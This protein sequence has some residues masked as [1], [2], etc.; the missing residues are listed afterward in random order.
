MK[1]K[2]H[3]ASS[4]LRKKT[5]TR[6]DH[7]TVNDLPWKTVFQPHEAGVDMD[8]GILELEEVDDGHVIYEDTNGGRVI[9]FTVSIPG[10]LQWA[11]PVLWLT[12]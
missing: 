12:R 7:V 1:R 10:I 3:T 9:R 6:H 4:S 2:S 5:K 8:E 11:R